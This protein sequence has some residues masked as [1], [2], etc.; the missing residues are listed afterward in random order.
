MKKIFLVLIVLGLILG[1]TSCDE[2]SKPSYELLISGDVNVLDTTVTIKVNRLFTHIKKV[3]SDE[4]LQI[5]QNDNLALDIFKYEESM[6]KLEQFGPVEDNIIT[7]SQKDIYEL[8]GVSRNI[9]NY[10]IYI[11]GYVEPHKDIKLNI[12]RTLHFNWPDS[13]APPPEP[14]FP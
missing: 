4:D 9:L 8:L 6:E 3:S 14:K 11:K 1:I 10:Y 7:L 2:K 13:I 5:L 12:N